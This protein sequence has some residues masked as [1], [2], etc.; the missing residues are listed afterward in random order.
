MSEIYFVYSIVAISWQC[1][2][3]ALG[4]LDKNHILREGYK[5]LKQISHFLDVTKNF[6]SSLPGLLLFTYPFV[7]VKATEQSPCKEL[8]KS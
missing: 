2:T 5:N 3:V 8:L 1:S 6:K 7:S 4:R